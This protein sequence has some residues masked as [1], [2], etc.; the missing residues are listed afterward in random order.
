V[1]ASTQVAVLDRRTLCA[2]YRF[3]DAFMTPVDSRTPPIGSPL[4][5]SIPARAW[6]ALRVRADGTYRFSAP[7]L[8]EPAPTG[9]NL[10]VSVVSLTGEY[11]APSPILLTLPLA[12][13]VPPVAADFL[14]DLPLWPTP[15]MRPPA[16]ETAVRG[17]ITSPTSQPVAGLQVEMWT[18][19]S[20][21]PPPGTP[22]TLTDS[23]GEFLYRFPRLK[24][25]PGQPLPVRIRLESGLLP[26]VP[27]SL[28]LTTG[29]PQI[30]LFQRT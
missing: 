15:S 1:I 9:V 11:V 8:T 20:P 6:T 22:S 10:A 21:V 12:V 24:A 29:Q 14:R 13:S 18:G 28:S 3:F 19:G 16:G 7:T 2:V 26:I 30:I 5:V 17:R 27:A 4:V 23:D 25:T